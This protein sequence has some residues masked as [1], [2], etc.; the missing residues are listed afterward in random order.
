MSKSIE[1]ILQQKPDARPRIYEY[2]I[3]GNA[4][5]GLLKIGQTTR[6]VKQRVAER[7]QTWLKP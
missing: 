7:L 5:E 2:S 3:K 6:G 4:H 1:Q